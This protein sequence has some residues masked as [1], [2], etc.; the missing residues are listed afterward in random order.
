MLEYTLS[1]IKPDAIRRNL[2]GKI[3]TMIEDH[4]FVLMALKM[5]T[6][7]KKDAQAFYYVH[8]DKP[9]YESLCN[10][11]S[12]TPVVVMVLVKQNAVDDLRT[13]MGATNPAQ[14][15]AG[16]I[17]KQYAISIEQNSIHGSDAVSSA[18]RE[19]AFFFSEYELSHLELIKENDLDTVVR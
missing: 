15:A 2:A 18:K 13:L 1:I 12:S 7:T 4:G 10:F 3:L 6:L 9:F 19:I 8:R 11:M 5:I 16:T 17:R 14:A